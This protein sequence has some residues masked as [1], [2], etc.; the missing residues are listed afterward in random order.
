MSIHRPNNTYL[1]FL[2]LTQAI[3]GEVGDAQ[4]DLLALR[5]LEAAAVAADKNTPLTVTK[6]MG[7]NDIASPA[8]VHRKLDDLLEAGLIT[9]EF[10]GKDRRTKYIVPTVAAEKYFDKLGNA[11]KFASQVT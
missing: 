8:T 11:I 2:N 1:R 6:A 9:L 5:L 4:V 3:V 10:Q 7:L